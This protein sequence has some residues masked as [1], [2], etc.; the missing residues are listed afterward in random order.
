M[1]LNFKLSHVEGSLS[2]RQGMPQFL[3]EEKNNHFYLKDGLQQ[4]IIISKTETL[5]CF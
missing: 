5:V 1:V 4:L 2:M 3:F